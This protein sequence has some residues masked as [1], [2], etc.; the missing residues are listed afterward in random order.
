MLG[1][2]V[3]ESIG[4]ICDVSR[5][6]V[7][8]QTAKDRSFVR[9]CRNGGGTLGRRSGIGARQGASGRTRTQ[10]SGDRDAIFDAGP[11]VASVVHGPEPALWAE[12]ISI[13]AA[14]THHGCDPGA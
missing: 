12:A 3:F 8:R 13:S 14:A 9:G 11:V 1:L 6:T 7:A 5:V 4:E 10:R 2:T